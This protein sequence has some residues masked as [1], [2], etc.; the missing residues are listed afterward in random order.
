MTNPSMFP[1]YPD[2]PRKPFTLDIATI[3]RAVAQPRPD[4]SAY[5]AA[6]REFRTMYLAAERASGGPVAIDT[7]KFRR[8]NCPNR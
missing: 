4:N 5:L 6:M 8:A 3:D 7:V 1:E 2:E